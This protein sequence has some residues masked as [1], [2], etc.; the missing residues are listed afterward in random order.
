[1]PLNWE[2]TGFDIR[3]IPSD[4][5]FGWNPVGFSIDD[6]YNAIVKKAIELDVDWLL[7][8]EDDVVVPPDLMLKVA[9]YMNKGKVPIVSGLYY[10]KGEPTQPL[11][12]RGRGNGAFSDFKIG[13]KVW[14]DG[15]P[16]GCFLIHTSI[17]KWFWE[18]EPEYI[19]SNGETARRVFETPRK[20]FVDPQTF[21]I[22]TQAGTQDLHFCD[23]IIDQKVLFETGWEKIGAL[24]YP[25]LVDTS[26]FCRHIDRNTGR[27]YP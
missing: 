1:M 21:G 16:M 11:V 4:G 8:I 24:E 7:V 25:F 9:E 10:L 23:R 2:A 5:L 27:Q 14:A 19:M 12:F 13:Q 17:L 20:L 3:Y 26:I 22:Y 18:R 6:A 15:V